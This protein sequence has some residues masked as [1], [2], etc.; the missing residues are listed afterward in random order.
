ML[1]CSMRCAVR[2]ATSTV[3]RDRSSGQTAA[4][5]PL[6]SRTVIAVRTSVP[7]GTS[8]GSGS[9][10]PHAGSCVPEATD[11]PSG[12][13]MLKPAGLVQVGP[14]HDASYAVRTGQRLEIVPQR[15][16]GQMR[17]GDA[18]PLQLLFD[19]RPLEGRLVKLWHKRGTRTELLRATTD[20]QGKVSFTPPWP[21]VWMASVVQMVPAQETPAADWDSFW[22]NLTFEIPGGAAR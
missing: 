22:G 7:A 19:G 11:Q 8:T 5:G 13:S 3:V 21:G 9:N 6:S 16:P 20:G 15:H 18:L 4:T 12:R 1:T 10:Q 17:A 2:P 14:R